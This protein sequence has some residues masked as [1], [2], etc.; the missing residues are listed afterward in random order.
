MKRS[1]R[2]LVYMHSPL[3]GDKKRDKYKS[4]FS[5]FC[6]FHGGTDDVSSLLE[7]YVVDW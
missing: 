6:G 2:W 4:L 1:M 3:I 5:E 7:C